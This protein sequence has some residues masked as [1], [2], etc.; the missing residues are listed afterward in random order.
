MHALLGSEYYAS[1]G[2]N[3]RSERAQKYCGKTEEAES[4]KTRQIW[5]RSVIK[6]SE[7]QMQIAAGQDHRQSNSEVETAKTASTEG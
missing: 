1:S 3:L 5:I 4:L 6:L 7:D 2:R